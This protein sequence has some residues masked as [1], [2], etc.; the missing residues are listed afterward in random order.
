MVSSLQSIDK[1]FADIYLSISGGT[2]VPFRLARYEGDAIGY[3]PGWAPMLSP[4]VRQDNYNFQHQPPEIDIPLA[5]DSWVGGC[6]FVDEPDTTALTSVKYSYSQ[7][8]DATYPGRLYLS[9]GVFNIP[10]STG[11]TLGAPDYISVTPLGVYLTSTQYLYKLDASTLTWVPKVSMGGSISFTGE[12]VQ[13][14]GVLFAPCGDSAAY[15]TSTDGTTWTSSNLADPYAKKFVARGRTSTTPQLWKISGTGVLKSNTDGVNGGPAWSAGTPTGHSSETVNSLLVAYD[16][17]LVFKKEGIYS[18]DGTNVEDIF[19]ADYIA[20][21]NGKHAY[22]WVDGNVYVPYGDRLMKFNASNNVFDFVFPTD[23]MTGH[24]EINGTIH[25]ISGNADALFFLLHNSAGN[26]YTIK[27]V[28]GVA[29]HTLIYSGTNTGETIKV[30]S[31]TIAHSTNPIII[32]GYTT[33]SAYYVLPRTGL[34]PEDDLN[35]KY[36]SAGSLYGPSISAGGL[37]IDKAIVGGSQL[38]INASAGKTVNLYYSLDE[39]IYTLLLS[40]TSAGLAKASTNGELLFNSVRNAV[41]MTTGDTGTSP[42]C[43][44]AGFNTVSLPPRKRIWELDVVLSNDLSGVGGGGFNISAKYQQEF[45]DSTGGRI[46]TFYDRD[47][48]T[49]TVRAVSMKAASNPTPLST[50][51]YLVYT[52]LIAEIYEVVTSSNYLVWA[53]SAWDQGKRWSP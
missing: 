4:S 37:T 33:Y 23:N 53:Q 34:R 45:L 21:Q 27:G 32:K 26:E 35:Y 29:W 50:H 44:A 20:T 24:P 52:L 18:F 8:V 41:Y 3:R 6:G 42:I 31:A 48:R 39:G 17:L 2:K 38:T 40:S 22:L 10:V 16:L 9:P 13:F 5:F 14:N 12:V 19:K 36:V 46:L 30:I 25:G 1:G 11:G 51:D 43:L 49:F 28:P 47:G 15:I 7:G